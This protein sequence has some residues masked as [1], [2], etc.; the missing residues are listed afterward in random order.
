M[1]VIELQE[2]L[3]MSNNS[4]TPLMKQYDQIKSGYPDSILLYRMGDFYETFGDDAVVASKLLGIVLT[5]RA[6]GKASDV[7]LAGFPYHALD[8]Y[9]PK[10]VDGGYRVALCEQV[11]D[12][13]LV[14]GIVKREVI[15]VV[16][17][18][19]IISDQIL[20]QK[21]NNYIASIYKNNGLA[22][23]S[24]IDT[25]TG[26]YFIGQC[27]YVD[28]SEHL[29]KYLPIEVVIPKSMVYNTE[30]WFQNFKPFVTTIENRIFN[31]GQSYRFLI[32]HF[33]V[34]SLKGYG[35]E[36]LDMGI[37]AGG[38]LLY[39]LKN[40]LNST[41]DHFTKLKPI[42]NEGFMG[43]D[44]FTIKN[45]EIFQSISS[46]DSK[47]TL[48]NTIDHTVTAGGGRLL[49]KWLYSPLADEKAIN[50]RLDI[51]DE[52]LNKKQIINT[53]RK[54]FRQTLDTERIIAKISRNSASPRD[55][56]GISQT[57]AFYRSCIDE[58][59]KLDSLNKLT[60]SYKDLSQLTKEINYT[61]NDD[62]PSSIKKGNIIKAGIDKGLD[63]LRD[64]LLKT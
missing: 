55:V 40:N 51:V 25:S 20:S 43:L 59:D 34:K 30:K 23:I 9:L 24:V 4:K 64:I 38:A 54:F 46:Q 53:L 27:D 29:T 39:H 47:G 41:I 48:I 32:E 17:P 62:V 49:K 44:G 56:I 37:V 18:G 63:D 7:P 11:E 5:K 2:K 35:C 16:S 45:L 14:K 42:R 36:N 31:Y 12:P 15:E 60:N 33:K 58:V 13:K 3:S 6:N 57:F 22:G 10:L 52:L 21:N 61:L 28:I 8:N 19:T 1:E 26:E 50:E